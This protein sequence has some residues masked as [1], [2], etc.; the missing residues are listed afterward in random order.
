[1]IW[2]LLGLLIFF[3][4]HSVRIIADD[5]RAKFI[6]EK[7]NLAWRGLFSVVSLVGLVLIIYGFG[8]SRADPVFL[9]NPPLWTRHVAAL[10]VLV[11]F[12]LLVAAYIPRNHIKAKLGHPM[13]LGIK[14]WAFAHLIA[15]G[16]LGDVLLFG[17]FLVWAI[18]GYSAARKRDRKAGVVYES[19]TLT[20]SALVSS[21]GTVAYA[22]FAFGLHSLLIGV[23]VF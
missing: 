4:S 5:W 14:V 12:F 22:V 3:A 1:M 2:L 10:L 13:F 17:T 19:G 15:N 9:W 11:A 8:M 16:R 20:G 7:G 23:P 21:A 18:V 6:A